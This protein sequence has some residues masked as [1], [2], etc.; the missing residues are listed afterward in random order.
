MPFAL[1]RRHP[2]HAPHKAL[3]LQ[4]C[5]L[6]Q[7]MLATPLLA[8]LSEGFPKAQFDWALVDWARPAI[9]SNPRVREIISIGET[10]LRRRSWR[11]IG[12]LILR[13]RKEHYDTAFIPSGSAILSY[14]A[15]EAGIHQR[16]GLN[17]QGRGF[18]HTIPV[19]PPPDILDRGTQGLLLAEAAGVPWNISG[20]VNMEYWPAREER[21][22][23]T[24]RLIE[25]VGWLGDVPLVIM[26]PGG[27][28]NPTRSNPL[29]RWPEGRF[30][31][32]GNHLKQAHRATIILV[33]TATE[34]ALAND[35]AG[36][37]AGRVF[38]YCGE[39]GLGEV[40]ALCE[41]A[42]LF[43][44]NDTV[45]SHIAAASGCRTLV[46]Y[47]PTNPAFSKPYSTRD[48]VHTLWR[49]LREVPAERPFKWEMGV[50]AE[51]AMAA[52][53]G[54]LGQTADREQTLAILSGKKR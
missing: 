19:T 15:W 32:L 46:I 36:M 17:I 27:G 29:I 13:L 24:R 30:V 39:L 47:G 21:S 48:N 43:V 49:D 45:T 10:D 3:I 42:D 28:D 54:I 20:N 52:V 18:A 14:I 26:H 6:S 9:A 5:C 38:N 51:E 33:G 35:I 23:V 31:V 53:D 40:S 25:E 12:Q 22:A 7:V 11:Q 8:A 50:T 34:K 4:T 41:V 37:I 16:I 2:L 44:G 1:S